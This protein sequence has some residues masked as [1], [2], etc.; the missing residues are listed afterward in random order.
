[1]TRLSATRWTIVQAAQDGDSEAIRSL[2]EKYW[3]AVVGYLR[4][5][6]ADVEGAEDLAQEALFGLLCSAL[7]RAAPG[8]G[9]FRGLVFSI[10]RNQLVKHIEREGA[11]KRGGGAVQRLGDAEIAV[12]T[13]DA[14]FDLEWL[15]ALLRASLERLD[16]EH[17][18]YLEVLR[19]CLLEEQ[20]QAEVATQLGLSVGVV[21]KRVY[22]GKRKLIR[23]LREEV[24]RY[25]CTASEYEVELN[26]LSGL[27]GLE[28][29]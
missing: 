17:P 3:P 4:R 22:R 2:C 21:K 15:G 16:E 13:P 5:R 12:E 19:L 20:S 7:T 14:E 29:G 24:W 1:M 6:G 28:G 23:Y 8:A 26:Y 10:A 25:A 27:L 18:T 9:R 11:Q